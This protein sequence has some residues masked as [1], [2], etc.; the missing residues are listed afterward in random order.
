MWAHARLTDNPSY[1]SYGGN[2]GGDTTGAGGA[3][4][5]KWAAIYDL[6]AMTPDS[7]EAWDAHKQLSTLLH[8]F[9]HAF[10]AGIGEYYSLSNMSDPTGVAPVFP[11][12]AFTTP[13]DLFW[14]AR[15]EYWGDPLRGMIYGQSAFGSPTDMAEIINL[16]RFAPA[17]VGVINGN[18]RAAERRLEGVPALYDVRVRV[19]A[20]G[21]GT[22]I[23]GAT[24]RVWNRRNPGSYGDFEAPVSATSD[25][26][27]F[28]F[29]WSPR[30][31]IYVFGNWDNAKIVKVWA[32]GF[33]AKA[34]WTTIYEAQATK[35]IDGSDV[36]V[37]TVE[38]TPDP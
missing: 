18:Y 26:S 27:E 31:S 29:P 2:S 37:I 14:A 15:P 12:T 22:P 20:A 4:G 17:S 6:A 7:P 32:P 23:T 30:P 10:G 16:T 25:P 24:V 35:I 21:T 8:E 3:A 33:A 11:T 38:L 13:G 9:E 28:R 34:Q 1:G 36:L 5:L 19:V